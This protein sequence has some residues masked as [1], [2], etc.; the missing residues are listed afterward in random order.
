MLSFNGLNFLGF[1]CNLEAVSRV[2][3]AKAIRKNL[4]VSLGDAF[5]I[6]GMVKESH[7]IGEIRGRAL[8]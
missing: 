1:R 8:K 4:A 6:A 7:R 3:L 5:K 2:E